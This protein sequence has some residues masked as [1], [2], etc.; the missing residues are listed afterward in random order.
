MTEISQG[1]VNAQ[2][3]QSPLLLETT[4][5]HSSMLLFFLNPHL[6]SEKKYISTIL[7]G[8][9]LIMHGR[10]LRAVGGGGEKAG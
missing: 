9:Y 2:H 8:L 1:S 3:K 5:Q 10:C 7:N 6:S 4:V